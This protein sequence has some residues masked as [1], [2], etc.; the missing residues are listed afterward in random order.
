MK[1]HLAPLAL[2]L[3][4]AAPVMGAETAAPSADDVLSAKVQAALAA[5]KRLQVKAPLD[6]K[7]R[8]GVVAIIGDVESPSMVYRAVETARGVD[9]VK[10]VDTHHL[11]AR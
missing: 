10:D 3:F 9:G 4:I 1:I 5:D 2:S 6:V 11:E 7:S 8:N